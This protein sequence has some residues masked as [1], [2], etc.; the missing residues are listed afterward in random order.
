MITVQS[1]LIR[2]WLGDQK[3]RSLCYTFN[4]HIDLSAF[5]WYTI[6]VSRKIIVRPKASFWH[7]I[8]LIRLPMDTLSYDNCTIVLSIGIWLEDQTDHSAC[9]MLNYHIDLSAF[10]QFYCQLEDHKYHN[11]HI[12]LYTFLW[13]TDQK[14][15]T[16]VPCTIHLAIISIYLPSYNIR[17]DHVVDQKIK[18]IIRCTIH[19]TTI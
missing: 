19:L 11:D 12:D 18:K 4:D 7:G 15:E 10:L 13:F 6:I 17:Y 9:C 1:L 8:C 3:D 14:I 2:I 5:L 16:I